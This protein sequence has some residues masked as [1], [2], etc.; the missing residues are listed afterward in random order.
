MI[1]ARILHAHSFEPDIACAQTEVD[2]LE[3]EEVG[4]VE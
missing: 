4:F 3:R 1:G 2:I